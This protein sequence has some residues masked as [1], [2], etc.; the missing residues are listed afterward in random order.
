MLGGRAVAAAGGDGVIHLWDRQTRTR[1][2]WPAH[3]GRVVALACCPDGRRFV[4]TGEDGAV[5]LW[6]ATTGKKVATYGGARA[7]VRSLAVSADG[8]RLAGVAADGTAHLWQLATGKPV[9]RTAGKGMGPA[10]V[11]LSPADGLL[12]VTDLQ[13]GLRLW[14]PASGASVPLPR[15]APEA[16]KG[17]ALAFA[18][19]GT[20]A[21]ANRNAIIRVGRPDGAEEVARFEGHQTRINALLFTPDG[22]SLVSASDDG[23]LLIWDV[24]RRDR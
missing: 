6:E 17:P 3:Q 10:L 2:R 14:R 7:E 21:L 24:P 1:T 8:E 15:W 20:L 4:S 18:P 11:A 22:K 5:C 23:T 12:A 9:P 16:G 13:T 19:D